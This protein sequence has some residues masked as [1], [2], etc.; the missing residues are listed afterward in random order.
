MELRGQELRCRIVDVGEGG[1]RL[2]SNVRLEAGRT[3]LV[4]APTGRGCTHL[5]LIIKRVQQSGRGF[6]L[7]AC[8]DPNYPVARTLLNNYYR[9]FAR[10]VALPKAA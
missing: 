3:L 10:N 4:R 8:P 2:A 5:P 1:V 7:S 6:E 9:R